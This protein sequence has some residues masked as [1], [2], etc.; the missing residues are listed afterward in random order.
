MS[1]RPETGP[2]LAEDQAVGMTRTLM[3]PTLPDGQGGQV[4]SERVGLLRD[5]QTSRPLLVAV[6]GTM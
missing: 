5:F 4:K 3:P 6:E 2:L 1:G